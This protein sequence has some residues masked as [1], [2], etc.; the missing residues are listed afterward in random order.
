MH[1]ILKKVGK[2]SLQTS[3][4]LLTKIVRA[5]DELEHKNKTYDDF[6][7]H[8]TYVIKFLK[9]YL[10]KYTTIEGVSLSKRVKKKLEFKDKHI[11]GE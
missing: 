5:V 9:A 6:I 4:S 3:V 7:Y 11:Y 8:A 2:H 10:S 1:F